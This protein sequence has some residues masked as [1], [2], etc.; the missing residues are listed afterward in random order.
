MPRQETLF[1]ENCLINPQLSFD[2]QKGNGEWNLGQIQPNPHSSQH[3]LSSA[4]LSHF[5]RRIVDHNTFKFNSHNSMMINGASDGA[6]VPSLRCIVKLCDLDAALAVDTGGE[7]SSVKNSDKQ[8]SAKKKARSG[9]F[10]KKVSME[11]GVLCGAWCVVMCGCVDVV[12][13]EAVQCAVC[14]GG[15]RGAFQFNSVIPSIP[16]IYGSSHY[17]GGLKILVW[18][19]F[20]LC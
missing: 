10:R 7:S 15:N 19:I 18:H 8:A 17:S 1:F 14:K 13:M 11:G 12:G 3:Q 9:S 6:A 5:P 4:A 16:Y 20:I 2:P